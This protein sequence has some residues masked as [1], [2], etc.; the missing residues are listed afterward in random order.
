[1]KQ[2]I[3][4]KRNAIQTVFSFLSEIKSKKFLLVCDAAFPFLKLS[5]E[6]D[7]CPIAH[8]TFDSFTPNPLYEDICRGTDLFRKKGCDAIVAVGGGSTMDAAKCIKLFSTMD[9]NQ[10]YLEQEPKENHIPLIAVPTTAGTGSESTR[11]A[12]IYYQGVKQSVSSLSAIPQIAVL[13]AEVLDTLPIYQKKCTMMDALCQGI[14]S[15]WSVNSTEESKM[16]SRRA[17]RIIMD[18]MEDYLKGGQEANEAMLKA[19]NLTGQAI[20]ITQTTAAHA[21]SYKLTS[22]FGLPHGRA[23]AICLPHIWSYML[24]HME[25]CIDHRGREYLLETLADIAG[26]LKCKNAQDAPKKMK[27]LYANLFANERPENF[28]MEE[29]N[30]LV[31]SVNTVRLKNHPVVLSVE[32]INEL[33]RSI[34]Y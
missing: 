20:N 22:L 24:S 10:N 4:C 11:F 17:V 2:T 32:A 14:E 8:V 13:D 3:L 9:S 1:M 34:L 15:W 19:A 18:S 26:E 28:R 16:L 7:N 6:F 29:L 25:E 30:L 23:V 21:M 12:V 5:K 33:Y 31:E 27:D